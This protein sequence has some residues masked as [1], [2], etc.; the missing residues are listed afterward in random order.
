MFNST[1]QQHCQKAFNIIC[2]IWDKVTHVPLYFNDI[3]TSRTY[4]NFIGIMSTKAR[5]IHHAIEEAIL[6]AFTKLQLCNRLNNC[7]V[8][9]CLNNFITYQTILP[10]MVRRFDNEMSKIT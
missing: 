5:C 7:V 9:I 3:C 8:H 4:H 6:S 2:D 1:E 10:P